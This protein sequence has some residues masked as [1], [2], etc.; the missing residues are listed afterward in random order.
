L[1]CDA[2][3]ASGEFSRGGNVRSLSGEFSTGDLCRECP[4]GTVWGREMSRSPYWITSVNCYYFYNN[5]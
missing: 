1:V 5:G 2:Q 3:Q 4:G